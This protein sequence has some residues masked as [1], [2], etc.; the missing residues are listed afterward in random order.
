MWLGRLFL[1]TAMAAALAAAFAYFRAE[2]L[3]Q[4]Q[5]GEEVQRWL[6][7]ARGRFWLMGLFIMGAMAYLWWLILTQRYEVA[8]VHDYTNRELPTIYRFAA[9][10]GG[11]AG[12]WMMWAF[13]TT[14]WGLLLRKFAQPYETATLAILSGLNFLLLL[15]VAI[16]DPFRLLHPPPDDG[17]GLNPLLQNYWMAIHPPN[18]FIGYASMG[19]PFAL[20]LAGLWRKDWHGWT[21]Y[22]LPAACFGTAAL[23]FGI[24]L[25]G[26]WSYEV[27][28][29]GGYWAWDPVENASF[30]PW[31]ACASLMHLLIV[32]RTKKSASRL[33]T[34]LALSTFLLAY[35]ATFVTRSGFIQ[36]VHNFGTSTITWWVLGIMAFLTVI[37]FGLLA[38]RLKQV[39]IGEIKPVVDSLTS[40][41][42]FAYAGTVV[43]GVF[44]LIVLAG[45]S[46]PWITIVGKA[47][48]FTKMGE[49]G[50]ERV[51]YDR[52][53][54]PIAV[55]MC[56][57]LAFMPL[58]VMVRPKDEEQWRMW[59]SSV[60]WL[61]ANGALLT[62]LVAFLFG[63]RQPVS[64][65]LLGGAAVCIVGNG[66]ALY[67]R[68]K[69]SPLTVGAYMAHLGLGVF[70]LGVVGSELRDSSKQLIIPAGEHRVA[71]GF[72]FT[73][74][75]LHPRPDG[76]FEAHLH[77]H[78]L[79][80]N[81]HG[82]G[83][84][85]AFTANPVFW[86]T[87]FGLVREPF[88]KRYLTHDIYI[89]PVEYQS[90][91]E[92]GVVT[93]ARGEE[94]KAGNWRIKFARFELGG[95]PF[96]G[97]PSK[98]AVVV[99]M[100]DGKR[101]H[102]LKPYWNLEAQTTHADRIAGTKIEVG[103]E[104]MNAESRTVTLHIKGIDGLQ[105]RPEFI[106]VNVQRKPAVNLVWLGAALMLL[107]AL[108]SGIRR[109][110]EAIKAQQVAIAS[111][112]KGKK[113]KKV[114]A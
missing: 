98:V 17:R 7:R 69:Q 13:F 86:D 75:G 77:A 113:A 85:P 61:I 90:P 33:T 50:V 59:K 87:A 30:V 73:F 108:L 68:A 97:M 23:G 54:F 91:Q 99:E 43:F 83:G 57:L 60:P 96:M 79:G 37:S 80:G 82:N 44:C 9:F 65:L 4:Q 32:Q 25:G 29:W 55:V 39:P 36:S 11:Q 89:E 95:K 12:T 107:G 52:A 3:V 21:R 31:L 5:K 105:G 34:V 84:E 42:F 10:W 49:F 76:K 70:L 81:G 78:R 94:I 27:L 111:E 45:L 2:L 56:L 103:I 93:L 40:L 92:A 8:Y 1:W 41:N 102:T 71:H 18:M 88:I 101:T 46:L 22:A 26:I 63:I 58:L 112:R 51:F 48:G 24:A 19:L 35:Y 6:F 106:V 15:P 28:G 67:L 47:L 20:A 16:E 62:A 53:S 72:L 66:Y 104:S 14:L 38:L 109:T 74:T 64:L 110:R 100:N 114:V